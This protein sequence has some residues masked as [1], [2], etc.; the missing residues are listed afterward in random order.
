MTRHSST[1]RTAADAI[2]DVAARVPLAPNTAFIALV[3]EPATE[4]RI[5][6]VEAL[7]TPSLIDDWKGAS[8]EIR[9]VMQR[10]R[11]PDEPRPPR[12]SALTIV[13]RPG[14][15]VFGPNEGQWL[16]AW[17]YS[18]HFANAYDGSLILV[19]EH[20]WVD[21][22]T[23]TAGHSPAMGSAVVGEPELRT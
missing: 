14:L 9:D 17:R 2:A 8:E 18:N 20:G 6:A 7:R 11:I 5:V 1:L 3:D 15:C 12:H 4:Q 16:S 13:V 10:F 19:T 21:F 23:D 22:M